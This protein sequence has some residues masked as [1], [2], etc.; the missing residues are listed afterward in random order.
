MVY[1]DCISCRVFRVRG[2]G[3]RVYGLRKCRVVSGFGDR[4]MHKCSFKGSCED[5]FGGL[6]VSGC[7]LGLCQGLRPKLRVQGSEFHA[8]TF[9]GLLLLVL[10][11]ALAAS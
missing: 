1:E 10:D 6:G 11:F 3:F 4:I 9:F 2:L 7:S 8:L 5:F